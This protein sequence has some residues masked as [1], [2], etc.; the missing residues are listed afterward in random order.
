MS[1]KLQACSSTPSSWRHFRS[2]HT[3]K[4]G[5]N[6]PTSSPTLLLH[7]TL[8]TMP[9]IPTPLLPLL[10]LPA[11]I[12]FGTSS[13]KS[14]VVKICHN[15]DCTKKGGGEMLRTVFRD[16]IPPPTSKTDHIQ[17]NIESSGCL[18]QCGKGPNVCVVN[19]NGNDEKM[20]FNIK[21]AIDAS[22]VLDVALSEANFPIELLVAASTIRQAEHASTPLEKEKLITSVIQD[23]SKDSD[24]VLMTSFAMFHAL[25]FRADARLDANNVDG[26]IDDATLAS[27]IFP[28]EGKAW[29]ILAMAEER[30]GSI[31][32]AI[33]AFSELARADPSFATKA[34]RE[35][36]R[37]LEV[38]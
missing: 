37:L 15:K 3:S 28:S 36:E 21:D 25:T 12:S 9:P 11:A 16:L 33:M 35:I 6:Q 32:S 13:Q 17:L 8:S 30:R 20:F 38:I 23:L 22:A 2:A 26:A 4:V 24:P 34:R 1:D 31:D 18:S 19:N 7:T 10:L 29:R 14:C 5:T 27:K